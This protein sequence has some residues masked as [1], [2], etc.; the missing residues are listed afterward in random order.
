M[1][2]T[3]RKSLK[4]AYA[5]F[6]SNLCS[7]LPRVGGPVPEAPREVACVKKVLQCIYTWLEPSMLAWDLDRKV[8]KGRGWRWLNFSYSW[9]TKKHTT[10]ICVKALAEVQV[11]E[12]VG[13][14][15]LMR[16]G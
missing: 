12:T 16:M 6:P 15:G 13:S 4:E 10:Q 11:L 7:L 1:S 2:L 8:E 9:G 14:T 5:P 3:S